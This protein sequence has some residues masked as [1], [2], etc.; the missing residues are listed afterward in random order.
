MALVFYR[1]SDVGLDRFF[2]K[3]VGQVKE[4][5]DFPAFITVFERLSGLMIG[6]AEWMLI[7]PHYFIH[8]FQLLG[9]SLNT[10][11]EVSIA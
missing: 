10:F 6:F 5:L 8:C 4:F 11:P 3:P 7:V 1:N 9:H 2:L